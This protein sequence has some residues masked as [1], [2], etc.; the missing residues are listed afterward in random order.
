MTTYVSFPQYWPTAPDEHSSCF[1]RASSHFSEG[2]TKKHI[3]LPVES[4]SSDHHFLFSLTSHILF[5]NGNGKN[6][7]SC[8]V[9][10]FAVSF[11]SPS[12]E[13]KNSAMFVIVVLFLALESNPHRHSIPFY[14]KEPSHM[15]STSL[16]KA[17]L[18]LP[19]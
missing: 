14:K 10:M 9:V 3:H 1:P 15:Y 13:I 5:N 16:V 2:N 17:L 12:K 6:S 4:L 7:L 11:R 18:G 19:D 8:H